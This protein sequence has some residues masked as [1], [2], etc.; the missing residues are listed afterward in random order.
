[1]RLR[2]H[3]TNKDREFVEINKPD[4]K[5]MQLDLV[6]SLYFQND[7]YTNLNKIY[8]DNKCTVI[9]NNYYIH[10][11]TIFQLTQTQMRRLLTLTFS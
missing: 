9:S 1:M 2:R 4:F 6:H 5:E 8:D 3:A 11:N 7:G 10:K